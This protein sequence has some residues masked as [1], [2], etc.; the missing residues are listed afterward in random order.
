MQKIILKNKVFIYPGGSKKAKWPFFSVQPFAD[1]A[2]ISDRIII[3]INI[4]V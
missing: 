2:V 4:L 1:T 3:L